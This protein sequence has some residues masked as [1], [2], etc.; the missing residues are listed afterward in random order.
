MTK[1]ILLKTDRM[2][3][4]VRDG[5]LRF[6][7]LV[8]DSINARVIDELRDLASVKLRQAAGGGVAENAAEAGHGRSLAPLSACYPEPSVLG[9]RHSRTSSWRASTSSRSESIMLPE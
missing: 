4:F 5:F 9:G 7:S 8:P 2:V 3:E 1:E 6:E